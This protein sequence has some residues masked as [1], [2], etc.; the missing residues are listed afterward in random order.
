[1]SASPA[2]AP[3]ALRGPV[4]RMQLMFDEEDDEGKVDP[5]AQTHAEDN[6]SLSSSSGPQ[7]CAG[8]PPPQDAEWDAGQA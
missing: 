5:R 8:N 7:E 6:K 3:C 1:M 4:S 2:R